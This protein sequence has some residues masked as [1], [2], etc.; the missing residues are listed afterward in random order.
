MKLLSFFTR[1]GSGRG[2]ESSTGELIRFSRACGEEVPRRRDGLP[3]PNSAAG[4]RV[5]VFLASR[6][7]HGCSLKEL[8]DRAGRDP[9]RYYNEL[10]GSAVLSWDL[11]D[12]KAGELSLENRLALGRF[13][14]DRW[15]LRAE[16]G[17]VPPLEA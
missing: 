3:S 5:R 14:M 7:S 9:R 11:V 16:A 8:A 1:R 13:L 10:E 15:G 6:E 17:R 4:E 12:Q 2:A